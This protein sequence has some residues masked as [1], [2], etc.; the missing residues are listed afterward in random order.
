MG[1][2]RFHDKMEATGDL[3]LGDC[4][5]RKVDE[6]D[7]KSLNRYV[8]PPLRQRSAG[9]PTPERRAKEPDGFN[10]KIM[11]P[12]TAYRAPE[13]LHKTREVYEGFEKHYL[14]KEMAGIQR[15]CGDYNVA[16]AGAR[17]TSSYDGMPVQVGGPRHGGVSDHQRE[18]YERVM[19]IMKYLTPGEKL[20]VRSIAVGSMDDLA[21]GR[22]ASIQ[23]IA[24]ARGAAYRDKN[25]QAK[26]FVGLSKGLGE[27]LYELYSY[28][29]NRD[30][31]KRMAAPTPKSRALTRTS[32]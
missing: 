10:T 9:T 2:R 30:R 6:I 14:A 28:I 3:Q 27:R 7:K 13:I 22:R 26:V 5:A 18:A 19:E 17:V 25:D 21:A 24:A 8:S 15:F 20:I 4:M 32:T 12:G 1:R 11:K 16:M 29:D 23:D 31:Q